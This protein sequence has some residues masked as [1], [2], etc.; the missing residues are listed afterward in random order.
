MKKISCR[1]GRALAIVLLSAC[2]AIP[3]TFG[4]SRDQSYEVMATASPV[5]PC[6]TLSWV[7]KY[8]YPTHIFRRVKGAATWEPDVIVA[9]GLTSYADTTALPGVTYEYSVG[10]TTSPGGGI[11][12]GSNLP[13]VESRGKVVLLVDNTMVLPLAPEIGQLEKNLAADGWI[14]IRHDVPRETVAP[15]NNSSSVWAA[16]IAEQ[17][18]IRALVQADYDS[19]PGGNWA[20]FILGRVP[21][22][23]SGGNPFDGHGDHAGAW[24]TDAYYADVDGTWSD[25]S[26]T[27]T[28]RSLA[29]QRTVNLAGDGKFDATTIPSSLEL[30][31]GRVDL[32][33][34]SG[35]PAGMTE[36]ELLRQYLVRDNN[37]RRVQAGYANVAR[38]GIVEDNFNNYGESA[39]SSGIA[40]FGRNAGQM[41]FLDFFTTVQTTPMLFA[42]GNGGGG[43]TTCQGVGESE[44]DFGKKDSKAVFTQLFGSYFGDWDRANNLL[45][46]PLGGTPNSLGLACSWSGS[47]A[48]AI[49]LYHMAMGD[50]IGY[51][52]LR[53]TNSRSWK[54]NYTG[55]I[56]SEL[57]GDPTL[58]LHSI[59]PPTR[60][61]AA[62]SGG[63]ITVSWQSSADPALAGYHV[64]RATSPAGPFTRIT[65]VAATGANPTGSCLGAGARSFTDAD[66][67]LAAGVSYTYLVKAVKIE[68]SASGTYANQ[69]LGEAVSLTHLSGSPAPSAPT[70]L[71]VTRTGNTT[72]L[73]TWDDNATDETGYLVER[74]DATS[75]VWSQIQSLS[76]NISTTSDTASPAGKIVYYRVR[77]AGATNSGYSNEAADYT[78]PGQICSAAYSFVANKA[79]GVFTPIASR[80]NGSASDIAATYTTSNYLGLAGTDYTATTGTVAWAHGEAADKL[81]GTPIPLLQLSTPQLTKIFKVSFSNPTN[82]AGIGVPATTYGFI[83]DPVAQALPSPWL[84]SMFG[85]AA[86]GEEGYAEHLDGTYGLVGLGGLVRGNST[87]EVARFL[88]QPV[89]GDFQF[90]ARVHRMITVDPQPEFQAGLAVRGSLSAY[91]VTD[92]LMQPKKLNIARFTRL[93]VGGASTEVGNP[94]NDT[95]F[96][97]SIWM[98][99]VRVG[100]TVRTFHSSDGT[101]W[102]QLG[103]G[104]A[105]SALPETAYVGFLHSSQKIGTTNEGPLGY[106]RF[107]NVSL[108]AAPAAATPGNFVVSPL[109]G[110]SMKLTW[111]VSEYAAGYRI[112]RRAENGTFSLLADIPTGNT[113]TYTDSTVSASV[114][115]QYRISS[116][117]GSGTSASSPV[118]SIV[119]STSSVVTLEIVA[120][121]DARIRYDS[122]GTAFG[123]TDILTVGGSDFATSSLA[124]VAK[125]YFRFDL[126]GLPALTSAEIKLT[127]IA[128]RDIDPD[129]GTFVYGSFSLLS[130]GSDAWAEAKINWTNAPQND[131]GG[132]GLLSSFASLGS[133]YLDAPIASGTELVTAL[134]ADSIEVNK[135][136][137]GKVTIAFTPYEYGDSGAVDF[138]SR[139]HATLPPPILTVTYFNPLLRPGFLTVTPEAGGI[140]LAWSDH[141]SNETNFEIQRRVANGDWTVV[142]MPVANTTAYTDASVLPGIIYEYRLRATSAAGNSDW[143]TAGSIV[144]TS[145]A[146]VNAPVWSPDSVVFNSADAGPGNAYVPVGFTYLPSAKNFVTNQIV[147]GSLHSSKTGWVGLKFTTG[148]NPIIIRQLA[149][150]VVSGNTRA[151]TVK[152]VDATTKA[153]VPNASVSVATSGQP[154]GFRYVALAAP[155]TLSANTSYYLL[156][157]ETAAGDAWYLGSNP[158]TVPEDVAT[159]DSAAWSGGGPI[160][161]GIES[162]GWGPVSFGYS[163]AP[164]AF[165]S[166]HSMGILRN[167]LSGWFGLKFTIGSTA[168]NVSE[169]A[170]WVAPGNTGNHTVKLVNAATGVDV[171]ST[172]VATSGSADGQFKYASLPL[173]VTLS[174]N[175]SYYLLTQETVGGDLWYDF[176]TSA[177]GT[178]TG[179]QEW[180]LANGLPM[181][182]SGQGSATATPASDGLP[183]LIKYA[184]GLD[185]KVSGNAG[186]LGYGEVIDHGSRYLSFTYTRPEPAPAGI[187]YSVEAS[188][189]LTGWSPSGVVEVG[190]MVESGL[191]TV[192]M[193]DGA[194]LADN[195][196]RFM[197]LNVAPSVP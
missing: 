87:S 23:Y 37:F 189:D 165:V 43:W 81:G 60:I 6:I 67:S 19:A 162:S 111:T 167:D 57:M 118:R 68:T 2:F 195:S 127:A 99:I 186:R 179:Y 126:S 83:A 52:H 130:D 185:P 176:A 95:D 170:R 92:M 190:S 24:S 64:Y 56:C 129:I 77:A 70:R 58:R 7:N 155:V 5:S 3:E 143:A 152:L 157:S 151:H 124:P 132:Y 88:C 97:G 26:V 75:G 16:R 159:V 71:V 82:G 55:Y 33:K 91:A 20:L 11:V 40:F 181:D 27:T 171:A 133:M 46:A 35:V 15:D 47:Y 13:I 31:C 12:A 44:R 94:W 197:R 109:S 193:R 174:A 59:A 85:I 32:S 41:D 180:L 42:Y 10:W 34:M 74:R 115:Y 79:D 98:R 146:T 63:G 156:T 140:G 65:G 39:W 191:R 120:E 104:T 110:T 136:A 89:S 38:R 139:E 101:S 125:T 150:W 73:L 80:L 134:D 48:A 178:A 106:A 114:A 183:N 122:P 76:A 147:S 168:L 22:P 188:D 194:P 84:S 158:A 50:S 131:T 105:H 177:A 9:T 61:T 90:T 123:A 175:T 96:V 161:E 86:A 108:E 163:T 144:Y 142:A 25:S 138:S 164:T 148:A 107:D 69:S 166:G 121:A 112:E 135:G 128:G 196:K 154:V 4:A 149:R 182:E 78:Q 54:E 18:A 117:N 36:T 8:A 160:Y 153:N 62:S 103:T 51:S 72:C 28:G 53:A 1:L 137:N 119:T 14:V 187:T 169:L 100:A 173:M 192:T 93:T 45:R 21:V 116:Y 172:V 49:P 145:A 141:S 17:S 66:A 113:A 184:L 30:Q 29:D 102:T